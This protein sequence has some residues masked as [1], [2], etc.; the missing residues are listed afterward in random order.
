MKSFCVVLVFSICFLLATTFAEEK[1]TTKYDNIDI[2]TVINSE[3]LLNGYVN[4]LLDHGACTPDAAELKKNLPD[5]LEHDCSACSAKQ[6]EVANKVSQYLIDHRREDWSLL[7]AK[8]DP[9][10]AYRQQYLQTQNKER[11]ID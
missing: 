6:K 11:A 10:G 9:T 4:C 7:E 1:Y 2:D 3:R 5:A 8:Y